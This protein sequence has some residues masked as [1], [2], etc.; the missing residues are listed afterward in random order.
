MIIIIPLVIIICFTAWIL[1]PGR[2]PSKPRRIAILA[3]VI[4]VLAAALAA[5]IF[6][7]LHNAAG[8]TWVSEAS[9]TCFIISVVII[10]LAIL[11]IVGLAIARK[12][13][14]VKG[15]GF[16]I[17]IGVLISVIELVLLEWLAGV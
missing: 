13:E 2:C 17:C 11:A 10:G 6:Q 14:I 12:W 16:G 8:M 4:P 5:V 15:I 3:T 7:L 1:R 9:N